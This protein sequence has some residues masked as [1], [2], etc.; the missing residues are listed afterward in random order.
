MLTEMLLLLCGR[1]LLER[2]GAVV[3]VEDGED[4]SLALRKDARGRGGCPD[5]IDEDAGRSPHGILSVRCV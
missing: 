1:D 3:E 4:A 2:E 5:A